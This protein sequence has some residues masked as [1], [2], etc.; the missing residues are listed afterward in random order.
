M[1]R[2]LPWI[3]IGAGVLALAIAF[4]KAAGTGERRASTAVL[5]CA[6][7]AA[8]VYA[9]A[10]LF[11]SSLLGL[12]DVAHGVAIGLAAVLVG[13]V[14]DARTGRSALVALGLATAIA[15]VVLML[16][17][18]MRQSIWLGIAVGGAL[19]AACG[20]LASE[21]LGT[22]RI[23]A[24]VLAALAGASTLGAF[25]E[26]VDRAAA[27]P[28]VIGVLGV[29]ALMAIQFGSISKWM[30][31]GIAA[32]VL[33]GG[34]KLIAIKYLFLGASF[35]VALGA[36]VC[37]A[38]VAWIL[39][40]ED[41]QAAGPFAICV[42]IWLAWSTIAF[43]LMQGV[44]LGISALFATVF[45]L[46][47]GSYRGLLSMSILVALGFYRVFLETYP[48]ESRQIDVGQQYAV[49]G[50]VAGAVL[51]VAV[52]T[53]LAGAGRQFTGL[54][55]PGMALLA[56]AITVAVLVAAD[57]ILGSRGTVGILIGL[58]I[59]P[60]VAGLS[61]GDRLGVLAA[62][63][64]LGA[65]V[66]VAFKFVAPHLLMERDAKIQILGWSIGAAIIL[67]AIA[68]W[69]SKKPAGVPIHES[70]A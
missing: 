59:A 62:I 49:M 2:I 36:V 9:V 32:V 29:I 67:V 50:I 54:M 3:A 35:N 23:T 5:A 18:D 61:P 16:P 45:L 22:D 24:F 28:A 66:V 10:S 6:I 55:R 58:S 64:G 34:A 42:M 14:L 39:E 69:L 48:T 43:G 4:S 40:N 8:L 46:A 27:L 30:K 17:Q 11:G 70:A 25:R 1:D 21:T 68:H 26:G 12:V 63:G 41:R 44:G 51:P 47:A 37:A 13:G 60:F 7:A 20:S 15:G 38:I 19:G 57:F 33:I 56:A 65:T 52:A 31:W 53:W